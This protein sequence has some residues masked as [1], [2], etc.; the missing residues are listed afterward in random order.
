MLSPFGHGSWRHAAVQAPRGVNG[1][2][3]ASW[4]GRDWLCPLAASHPSQLS[5]CLVPW[6]GAQGTW[7]WV[8]GGASQG[9][10]RRRFGERGGDSP[11]G[12]GWG[13]VALCEEG[14]PPVPDVAPPSCGGR[15]PSRGLTAA[16]PLIGPRPVPVSGRDDAG[17]HGS[18]SRGSRAGQRASGA[19]CFPPPRGTALHRGSPHGPCHFPRGCR[20]QLCVTPASMSLKPRCCCAGE[21]VPWLPGAGRLRGAG[22]CPCAGQRW[23]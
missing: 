18:P 11:R 3:C 10:R 9:Q 8:M 4:D 13:S 7:G 21:G 17:G 20:A 19:W 1:A 5:Q 2:R 15:S 22:C 16:L 12:G 23:D 6:S 14:D